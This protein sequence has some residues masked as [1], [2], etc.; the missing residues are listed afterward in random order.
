MKNVIKFI[1]D[2]SARSGNWALL[3]MRMLLAFGFY[4]PAVAKFKDINGTADMFAQANIPLAKLFVVLVGG[5]EFIGFFLL[6]LGLLTRYITVP[7]MLVML[8]AIL[9]VHMAN[10]YAAIDNGFQIPLT[11]LLMLFVIFSK[12]PGMYSIDEAIVNKVK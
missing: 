3:A 4:H 9:M 1:N 7:L 10:G 5:V 6:M 12:G 8:V 11:Y 2:T